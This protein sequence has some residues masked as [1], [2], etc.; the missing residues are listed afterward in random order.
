MPKLLLFAP[1][2]KIIIER[3]SNTASL[4]TILQ[5]VTVSIPPD[6]QLPEKA[7]VPLRWYVFTVWHKQPDEEGKRFAQEID[8][9]GPDGNIIVSATSQFEMTD[10]SYHRVPTFFPSFP[11]WQF[12]WHTLKLYLREDKEGEE[13]REVASF[14]LNIIRSLEAVSRI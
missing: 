3:E 1:C 13:K 11:I 7:A 12:G 8:L 4:I 2:E 5:D 6:A 10:Q 9:C 14:P